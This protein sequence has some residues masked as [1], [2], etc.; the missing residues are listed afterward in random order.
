VCLFRAFKIQHSCFE[1]NL[2][3]RDH[4]NEYESAN[5]F[6]LDNPVCLSTSKISTAPIAVNN[7]SKPDS[8]LHMRMVD[9]FD[10]MT[11]MSTPTLLTGSSMMNTANSH[12]VSNI[13][14]AVQLSHNGNNGGA[15]IKMDHE[16][17][18]GKG[19]KNLRPTSFVTSSTQNFRKGCLNP[20]SYV[21]V[22]SLSNTGDSHQWI[23]HWYEVGYRS[24]WNISAPQFKNCKAK[25]EEFDESFSNTWYKAPYK[26]HMLLDMEG[27]NPRDNIVA[28]LTLAF[29]NGEELPLDAVSHNSAMVALAHF[30][31]DHD[32]TIDEESR[33][34]STVGPFQF[35]VC[36]YKEEGRRFRMKITLADDNVRIAELISSPFVIRAKKPV[37][38]RRKRANSP[39]LEQAQATKKQRVALRDTVHHKGDADLINYFVKCD[40]TNRKQMLQK[41]FKVMTEKEKEYLSVAC[42]PAQAPVVMQPRFV[43]TQ[44]QSILLQEPSPLPMVDWNNTFF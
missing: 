40:A 29:E 8:F 38:R 13:Q 12:P 11:A 43:P 39:D 36:S 14:G 20:P 16:L 41:L 31:N 18:A 4:T 34:Q 44:P 21:A 10:M 5:H 23:A 30:P 7:G 15:K 26:Y 2:N 37:G 3:T 22:E 33:F 9:N 28:T 32:D 25:V 27:V 42:A 19:S 24:R 1:D 6:G 17:A 35:N